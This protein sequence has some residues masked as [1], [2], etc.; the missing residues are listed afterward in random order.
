MESGEVVVQDGGVLGSFL[1]AAISLEDCYDPSNKLV[2]R[3][4][5][6]LSILSVQC[7]ALIKQ[8]RCA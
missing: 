5:N 8:R 1:R 7:M 6:A 2:G 3:R 4:E